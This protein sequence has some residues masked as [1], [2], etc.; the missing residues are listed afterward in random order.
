MIATAL[1]V[2]IGQRAE[3]Q[4]DRRVTTAQ[5]LRFDQFD[6]SV[7]DFQIFRRGNNVDAV[8]LE[9]DRFGDLRDRNLGLGLKD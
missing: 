7:V 6:V 9:F 4:I 1:A 8:R 5:A 3:E 2:G